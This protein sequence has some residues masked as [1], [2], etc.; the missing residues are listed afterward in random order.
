MMNRRTF[1]Q[2][3]AGAFL[4]ATQLQALAA[5]TQPVELPAEHRDAVQRRRRRIVV[6]YD[7]ND[8]MWS[9][10]KLHRDGDA[11]FERF[12]DAVFSFVD[13]P[14]S[15][16]DAIWWDI[17]GSPLACAYPSKVEPPVEHPLLQRWLRDGVDWVEQLVSETRRR[18]LEVFWNHRISEVECLPE[19]GPSKQTHPLKVEHPDWAV[20]ASWWPRGMWNLAAAGLREHKVAILRELA[21]R[22]DLDGVQIDFSRHIPCLPVGRQW[23]LREEVT[24]FMRM[25]RRMLLEVAQQRGRPLML[26]AKT[27]QTLEGCRADGFDVKSWAEQHLVDVLTLGSRSMDVDVEGIRAAVG[28]GVQR[29]PCFDDHHATDGYRYGSIEFLRG[30]FANHFQRGADSVV[31]FNWSIGTPEIC[32]SVG[33]AAGPPAHEA[34]YKEVGDPQTMAGKD[35]VFAVERRGGY[36]WADGFFNRNDTAPLPLA[37]SDDRRTGRLT[38]HISDAP[39]APNSNLTLRC[40]LFQ[41]VEAD[42]FEIRFNG[43]PLSVTVRDA[44]WKD[45]Q[46]FSPRPQPTS[47]GKG[48]YKINL[49]Q[50]LLRLDCAVPRETWKRGRNEVEISVSSPGSAA[51]IEK[52]EAHLKYEPA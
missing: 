23:E 50:R 15:Q 39:T 33:A 25:V 31:T 40:V 3:S 2:A 41:A 9:Y 4:S 47:G 27:P 34:A 26:A 45:A 36:P 44:G 6:Q 43:T 7:A 18:K 30:V 32:H 20:A 14:G 17:G 37:L 11:T 49:Q 8:V 1:L 29:Q 24:E 51:Q 38:V 46:I 28:A 35:K 5:S 21:M 48:D 10:W 52:V 13:E 42:V 16:I 19:G 12:R 22:Y